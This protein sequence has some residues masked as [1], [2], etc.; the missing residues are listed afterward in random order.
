MSG[1]FFL[2]PIPCDGFGKVSHSVTPE[3]AGGPGTSTRR[4]LKRYTLT[5][6]F[7]LLPG[8]NHGKKK[9][10]ASQFAGQ[11]KGW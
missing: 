5:L 8:G 6:N 1:G 9:S 11:E 2:M 3:R 4:E 7:F 10:V